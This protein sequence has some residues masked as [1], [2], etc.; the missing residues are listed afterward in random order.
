GGAC[1]RS[2]TTTLPAGGAGGGAGPVRPP[3]PRPAAPAVGGQEKTSPPAADVPDQGPTV[4]PRRCQPRT[5]RAP[6][7][8]ANQSELLADSAFVMALEGP[9][10]L[11]SGRVPDPD[12]AVV[13]ARRQ[14]FAVR[15]PVHRRRAH[16]VSRQHVRLLIADRVPDHHAAVAAPRGQAAVRAPGEGG[17]PL[18]M[19]P[20]R[21]GLTARGRVPDLDRF[22]GAAGRQSLPVGLPRQRR[23]LVGVPE[24]AEDHLS[25]GDLPDPYAEIIA[26]GRGESRAVGA[27]RQVR[28]RTGVSPQRNDLV[29]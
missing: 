15:A 6:G 27:P 5:V 13:A 14:P 25:R 20:Q 16:D 19:P 7:E 12:L 26:A 28:D 21:E 8:R 2:D 22:V 10:L 23:D 18:P 4:Q 17:N 11:A 3:P 29:A 9:N 1:G 24:R